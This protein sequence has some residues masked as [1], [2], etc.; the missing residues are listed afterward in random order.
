MGEAG[1]L[2]IKYIIPVVTTIISVIGLFKGW[3]YQ[4]EKLFSRRE[5]MSKFIYDLYKV[6]QEESLKKLAI[7]YGYAAITKDNFL[8]TEQR[9]A[10]I[11]S[12][13]PTRDID[14]YRK[15]SSLLNIKTEPLSFQWKSERHKYKLYRACIYMVNSFFYLFGCFVLALPFIY[16]TFLPINMIEKIRLTDTTVKI[17]IAAYLFFGGG[18]IA[19]INLSGLSK[20]RIAG[21]LRKRH[22]GEITD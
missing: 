1:D 18:V 4:E 8:S 5:K 11:N 15:C 2:F 3:V 21:D 7:D 22:L 16:D 6:S 12:K 20:L 19:L 10:L 17:F 9:M 13:N 14:S